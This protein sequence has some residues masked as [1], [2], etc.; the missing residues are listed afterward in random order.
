M[1]SH[2]PEFDSIAEWNK[3]YISSFLLHFFSKITLQL[4]LQIQITHKH[5]L[6]KRL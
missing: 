4:D 1:Y 6:N 2:V 5:S 3:Q